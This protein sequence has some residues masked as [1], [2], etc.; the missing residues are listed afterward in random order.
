[1]LIEEIGDMILNCV[2][3]GIMIAM[4]MAMLSGGMLYDVF[5][6]FMEHIC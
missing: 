2:P 1:M 3:A 5:L 6:R 4:F